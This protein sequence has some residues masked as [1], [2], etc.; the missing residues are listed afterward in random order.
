MAEYLRTTLHKSTPTVFLSGMRLAGELVFLG[1]MA[2]FVSLARWVAPR[3]PPG[4]LRH[5]EFSSLSLDMI[6]ELGFS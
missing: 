5:L 6:S 4:A 3:R 2:C 1:K